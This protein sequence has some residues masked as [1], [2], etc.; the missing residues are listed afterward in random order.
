MLTHLIV[1][2]P[3]NFLNLIDLFLIFCSSLF[4]T[5]RVHDPAPWLSSVRQDPLWSSGRHRR[6]ACR[7]TQVIVAKMEREREGDPSKKI[8]IELKY[9][10][11]PGRHRRYACRETQVIVA[12]LQRWKD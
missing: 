11:S 1:F 12:E 6:H 9:I 2:V 4:L 5:G 3:G 8:Q 10:W 7:E